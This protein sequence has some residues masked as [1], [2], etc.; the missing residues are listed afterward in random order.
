MR[1]ANPSRARAPAARV[2][3]AWAQE[4]GGAAR[5]DAV[6]AQAGRG[7]PPL[8]APGDLDRLQA[9]RRLALSS[10]PAQNHTRRPPARLRDALPRRASVCTSGPLLSA[11]AKA[12]PRCRWKNR[13]NDLDRMC[14]ILDAESMP[15]PLR[16]QALE[17]TRNPPRAIALPPHSLRRRRFTG[18]NPASGYAVRVKPAFRRIHTLL[19]EYVF[20][21]FQ[22]TSQ[23][24]VF[25][26]YSTRIPRIP[27]NTPYSKLQKWTYSV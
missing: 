25:H 15:P 13:T 9:A 22:M 26:P 27:W 7:V 23:R 1:A 24:P 17:K 12:A 8:D 2:L 21:V 18:S 16:E 11:S 10:A 19:C 3:E 4:G 14:D 20:H 6:G 5:P